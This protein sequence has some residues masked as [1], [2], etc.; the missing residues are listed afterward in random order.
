MIT[1]ILT[2]TLPGFAIGA[3]MMALGGR[4]VEAAAR[5][6]RWLKFGVYFAVVHVFLGAA[7]AGRAWIL[8]LVSVIVAAGALELR[9][10]TRRMRTGSPALVWCVYAPVGALLL[11]DVW[12]LPPSTVAYVYL[13]VA[14]YD[15]FSQVSGQLFGRRPLVPR[16][17]PGKTVE[18]VAGGLAG[19]LIVAVALRGLA[20]LGP[21]GALATGLA[22]GLVGLVGDLAASWVKRSSGIKDYS[23]VLPGHGGVLDRFD[24]FL[25]AGAIVGAALRAL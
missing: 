9:G 16:T 25:L 4:R 24:S 3:V 13:V 7:A 14:V 2:V 5:R 20:G 11:V 19:A 8:I 23:N 15:G 17:S 18:G 12:R 10:A 1:L 22:T 6:E 21:L